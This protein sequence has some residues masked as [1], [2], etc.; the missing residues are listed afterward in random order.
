MKK[1]KIKW[2]TLVELIIV[3][4]ILAILA[5]IWFINYQTY[6]SDSRDAYRITTIWNIQ[7][8][9]EL[10]SI[11]NKKYPVPENVY[12][13]WIFNSVEL[14]YVW[15]I[16]SDLSQLIKL[17]QIPLDPLYKTY[18]LYWVSSDMK[19]YQLAIDLEWNLSQNT[20]LL[21]QTYANFST[22][23]VIWNYNYPLKIDDKL[24]DLPS[25][26]FIWTWWE[27]SSNIDSKAKFI[28]NNWQNQI[29]SNQNNQTYLD[30]K[31]IVTNNTNIVSNSLTWILIPDISA[32]DTSTKLKEISDLFW[33]S[34]DKIWEK[35]YWFNNYEKVL[36]DR[37]NNTMFSYCTSTWQV[38]YWTSD[39]TSNWLTC[40]SD[41]YVCNWT[42]TWFA[43]KSCNIWSSQLWTWTNRMTWWS[44]FQW[45]N[46]NTFILNVNNTNTWWY[47]ANI[48]T[49]WP[50]NYYS[51]WVFLIGNPWFS[52]IWTNLWWFNDNT[53]LSKK[54]PCPTWYHVPTSLEWTD[55]LNLKWDK[56]NLNDYQSLYDDL[57]IP[58][59][60]YLDWATWQNYWSAIQTHL[61]TSEQWKA[62]M[63][64][65]TP[66][67]SI[68]ARWVNN[69]YPIRC[70]KNL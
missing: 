55:L 62:L 60:R 3:I 20:N 4:T 2:F 7:K 66:N 32:M 24:Y 38:I 8:W 56:N 21:N 11:K 35:M 58:T 43:L 30:T 19:N 48:S 61:W 36:K 34:V 69:W 53:S 44:R 12:W 40:N 9:L 25:L 10:Y 64:Y 63:I 54:W 39:W 47:L 27:L 29:N 26:I 14:N 6:T 65:N 18:Y 49:N 13:T 28:V 31:K 16:K 1:Q 50:S 22:E 67:I 23:K 42:W 15:Y 17:N 33:V 57:Y 37:I 5:I 70:F 45:W 46:N 51:S 52:W 68:I 41:I 59:A